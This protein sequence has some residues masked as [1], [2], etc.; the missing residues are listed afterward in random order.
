M[1][2]TELDLARRIAAHPKWRWMRGMSFAD[3][4]LMEAH[5]FSAGLVPTDRPLDA[6]S[7]P[8]IADPATQGCLWAMLREAGP[9]A[10]FAMFCEEAPDGCDE[11]VA[12]FSVE[13]D[14]T[15]EVMGTTLGE[16]LARA[17]LA[18]WGET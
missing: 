8:V 16:A 5:R 15:D 6:G 12:H 1:T 17:L 9:H 4:G 13:R 14:Y 3:D 11:C 18:A 2:E 7:Y 10:H